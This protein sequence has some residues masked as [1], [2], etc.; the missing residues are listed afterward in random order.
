MNCSRPQSPANGRVNAVSE[1]E[2]FGYGE[3]VIVLCDEGYVLSGNNT[4]QCIEGGG[5]NILYIEK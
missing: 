1:M 2:T 5:T 4:R 3:T